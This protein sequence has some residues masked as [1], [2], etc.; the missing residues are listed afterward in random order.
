MTRR[1]RRARLPEGEF[2]AQITGMSH[3]GKGV[4]HVD[5]KATFI[6]GA[7]PGE[8]VKFRYS[9]VK[10]SHAEGQA[11]EILQAAPERAEPACAHYAMCGGCSLQHMDPEAQILA[12][13]QTLIDNLRQIGGVEP[14]E[15]WAPLRNK[16]P[17]GYRR[18]ARLG[19]KHV[20]AKGK[21]LVGFR[22]RGGRFVADLE[23]CEVLHPKVGHLLPQLSELIDGFSIRDRLPQ[24]EVA[25]DD[26]QCVL[27]FRVLDPLSDEDAAKLAAFAE[28]HQ[29][30]PYLQPGGPDTAAPLSG[31]PA[32]LHYT[33]PDQNVTL[34]FLPGD[35][36]QV[37]TDI[38]RQMVTRALDLL[39]PTEDDRVL[40]LFCG[41]GNF[42]LPLATRAG[43]V[44]G[45]EGDAGLVERARANAARN[46][47]SNTEF[48]TA[49]LYEDL[50]AEQ[51]LGQQYDKA[52]LD[53]PRSG[54][55]QVLGLLPKLG[56][57]SVLYISCYPG[58]LARDAGELVKQH[59]YELLG[60][61][62]MDM[63]PHTGHVESIALFKRSPKAR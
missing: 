24:I 11:T 3:D 14:G 43:S 33:L 1:R 8:T 42:T 34:G 22:E 15:V 10:K 19:V 58:T 51:W 61:G 56:I 35:F 26:E 46:G 40:D 36:T 63:F 16:T 4:A 50:D 38:N 2:E 30:I 9:L 37:N 32:D 53:P 57:D 17:W 59:G 55:Q 52:L 28:E 18:K 13:Q 6:H 20:H 25:M 31:E 23:R 54:A 60:A 62:V 12:K 41:V 27:I 29:V 39:A 5:D 44:T 21:V 7:L 45:V 49:N 48:F 47:L